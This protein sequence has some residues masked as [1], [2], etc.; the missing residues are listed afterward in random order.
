[1][2]RFDDRIDAFDIG[3]GLLAPI[4]K[5]IH[6]GEHCN[7]MARGNKVPSASLLLICPSGL[8]EIS[9]QNG[10]IL[11][12]LNQSADV[13][14]ISAV[15]GLSNGIGNFIVLAASRTSREMMTFDWVSYSHTDIL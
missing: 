9:P 2:G 12:N 14:Q 8:L 7:S 15:Q 6:I 4:G 13:T 1:L 3:N 10:Q 11:R 5:E